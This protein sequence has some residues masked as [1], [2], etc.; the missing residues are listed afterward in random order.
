LTGRVAL[1]TGASGD[2]GQAISAAL[3]GAPVDVIAVGRSRQRLGALAARHP[4]SIEPLAADL[5]R[6]DERATV[7][8]AVSRLGR[9]DM[10]VLASGIY[11]RSHD[12]A[13]LARQFAANVQAPYALP[14]AVLSLLVE[15][16]G[17]VV[18]I[19]S[20]Q[21]LAASPDVGQYA[22]TQHAM[23]AIADSLREEVNQSGVRVAL[24]FLGRTATTRQAAIFATEGRSYLPERLIQPADVA[25]I[26]LTLLTLPPTVE[27]TNISLRPR[28]KT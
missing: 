4:G 2:I 14:R 27:A 1:V 5:T 11:E 6:E 12:P 20:T 17:Q 25:G 28:L 3:A 10:L 21:G 19:N 15:A 16:S 9:L 8:Q 23:R 7:A 24:I 13:A 18:F 22:A 26:V